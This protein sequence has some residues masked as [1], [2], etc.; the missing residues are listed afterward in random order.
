MGDTTDASKGSEDP[1]YVCS[2]AQQNFNENIPLTLIIAALA[3]L[4]G[5]DR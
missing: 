5:A 3:E 4:N 1:L 2:R